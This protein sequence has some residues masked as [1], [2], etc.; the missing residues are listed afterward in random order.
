MVLL[1]TM[2]TERRGSPSYSLS[3]AAPY[4]TYARSIPTSSRLSSS[5]TCHRM[6]AFATAAIFARERSGMYIVSHAGTAHGGHVATQEVSRTIT[7][8]NRASTL[9][10]ATRAACHRMRPHS[11]AIC[12]PYTRLRELPLYAVHSSQ[13][14]GV[15][16]YRAAT[17][18]CMK[19]FGGSHQTRTQQNHLEPR[20]A[21]AYQPRTDN[22]DGSLVEGLPILVR[23]RQPWSSQ[24]GVG[25]WLQYQAR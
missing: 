12:K 14:Q 3:P 10:G 8:R 9:F 18:M 25:E 4:N 23:L 13:Q 15:D 5:R 11:V 6:L 24:I 2:S 1:A 16:A 17:L 21:V 22:Q 19:A 7:C 20:S